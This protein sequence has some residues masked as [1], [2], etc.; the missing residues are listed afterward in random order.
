MS[1]TVRAIEGNAIHWGRNVGGL[2]FKLTPSRRTIAFAN[3]DAIREGFDEAVLLTKKQGANQWSITF[4]ATPSKTNARKLK[5]HKGA[6]FTAIKPASL[7]RLYSA[8]KFY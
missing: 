5:V 2:D 6:E 8:H 4:Y 7:P 3:D 1:N